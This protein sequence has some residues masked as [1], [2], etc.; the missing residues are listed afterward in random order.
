[1]VAACKGTLG[2]KGKA[3]VEFLSG[4]QLIDSVNESRSTSSFQR[5]LLLLLSR[6]KT[7]KIFAQPLIKLE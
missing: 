2:R 1:M 6:S 3:G 7:R 4:P 5:P